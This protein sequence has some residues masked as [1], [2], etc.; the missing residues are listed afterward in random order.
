M[1]ERVRE[2]D[3]V[4]SFCLT[5]RHF[6][7][8]NWKSKAVANNVNILLEITHIIVQVELG[9]AQP[10]GRGGAGGGSGGSLIGAVGQRISPKFFPRL[11]PEIID[12][13]GNCF[14]FTGSS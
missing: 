8:L 3:L 11:K 14:S 9:T 1:N 12:P 6:L 4:P 2:S 5:F 10:Q 13:F 7:F